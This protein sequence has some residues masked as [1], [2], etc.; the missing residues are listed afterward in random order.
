MKPIVQVL[1]P[2]KQ[3][4]SIFDYYLP[5]NQRVGS[6]VKVPFRN[7][8]IEGIIWNKNQSKDNIPLVK[9]RDV[10]EVF[11][12]NIL[13]LDLIKFIKFIS[14]YN[15]IP[16]GAVMKF[17]FP[18]P[19]LNFLKTEIDHQDLKERQHDM[20]VLNQEQTKALEQIR[21][22]ISQSPIKPIL[23]EGITGSG[24]TAVYLHMIHDI[25]QQN[26]SQILVLFPE[27]MLT[28]HL[29]EQ[30]RN[31]LGVDVEIWH[32]DISQKNKKQI[33]QRVLNGSCKLVIGAR[34]ALFLPFKNLK[35]IVID[36]EHDH[37]YKQEDNFIYN[38]RDMAVAYGHIAQ[39]PIILSSA[40]PSLETIYNVIRKKYSRADL[41]SRYHDVSLPKVSI[42][43]MKQEKLQRSRWISDSLI[44]KIQNTLEQNKQVILFLNRK[45]YAPITLCRSC[46]Y[47]LN[48]PN[49][50]TCLVMYKDTV[51]LGSHDLICHRCSYSISYPKSCPSCELD[52][53]LINCGPG[54]DRIF[55][56]T[57]K[58][59]PDKNIQ[60]ITRDVVQKS[61]DSANILSES[62]ISKVDILIGTQV[63]SKGYHF[64]NLNLVGIIDADIGLS[65]TDLKASERTHQL[66]T[67]VGGRAGRESEGEV[68]IQTYNA[69]NPL[70][71][72]LK[73]YDKK[74]FYSEELHSRQMMELPP[75]YR[76]VAL[77]FSST[78][79]E[80]LKTVV[81]D[82]AAQI[83]Y[84]N[85]IE[86][87]GPVPAPIAKIRKH[88]RYRFLIKA[89]L[90]INLQKYI[91]ICVSGFKM[92]K[93]IRLKI[94][95]DPY[96]F[97]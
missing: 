60:A 28:H 72:A 45:G 51:A 10:S 67:Q 52:D 32:S 79:E 93:S 15:L 31:S 41:K 56:E 90:K 19:N 9:M 39:I 59:W 2:I 43:N 27:I 5:E 87:L 35:L 54:I 65:G 42:I 3:N 24:K 91:Q 29:V 71:I 8:E 53:V 48:C 38:A 94:D 66:L 82:F 37:S 20:P 47:K 62:N 73:T 7:K 76:L 21:K 63:L 80:K 86:V 68:I 25:L 61:K 92:P 26:N 30:F 95:I 85:N 6:I 88:Y 78:N 50:S 97:L 1:L 89:S 16:L 69:D 13:S 36:E 83:P 57:K 18:F 74:M 81:K 84:V 96:N 40:T 58:I 70:L 46:G 4:K 49:C 33:W 64:P 11:E 34:S 23:L 77:I 44:N 17:F 55:E 22:V 75:F 12:D 14:S